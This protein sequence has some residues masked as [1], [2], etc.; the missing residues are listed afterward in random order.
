MRQIMWTG[1]RELG[2]PTK[3]DYAVDAGYLGVQSGYVRRSPRDRLTVADHRPHGQR[4]GLHPQEPV[5]LGQGAA[6]D[7]RSDRVRVER[8][9]LR[10][11]DSLRAGWRRE[12]GVCVDAANI[13]ADAADFDKYFF[14]PDGRMIQ[15]AVE[16]WNQEG[17]LPAGSPTPW[18]RRAM[19][20]YGMFKLATA[21][22]V[23]TTAVYNTTETVRLENL[24][25]INIRDFRSNI[26][27][28]TSPNDGS[29]IWSWCACSSLSIILTIRLHREAQ[30]RC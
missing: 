21:H 5:S 1:E 29:P 30:G 2:W 4:S 11:S 19:L 16:A 25:S 10:S 14:A 17:D 12:L 13:Q 7:E 24:I 8:D 6:A 23:P 3:P 27:P 28:A 9:L 26:L 15:P 20:W 22:G 18:N